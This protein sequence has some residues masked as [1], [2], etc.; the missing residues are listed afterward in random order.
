MPTVVLLLV[1]YE[2]GSIRGNKTSQRP[3]VGIGDGV[4]C[5]FKLEG[6]S[7]DLHDEF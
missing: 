3:R 2:E 7:V 5:A 6:F 1:F 4:N